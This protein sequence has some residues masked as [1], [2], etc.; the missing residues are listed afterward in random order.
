MYQYNQQSV[1][2][3]QCNKINRKQN[4]TANANRRRSVLNTGGRESLARGL[5]AKSS[6]AEKVIINVQYI[7][8]D[9]GDFL[10]YTL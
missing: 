10:V 7:T 4:K 1:E 6:E 8:S 3:K 5:G 2:V 9:F